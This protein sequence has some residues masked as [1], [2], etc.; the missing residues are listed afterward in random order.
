L[1]LNIDMTK[2]SSYTL[3]SANDGFSLKS[4]IYRRNTN[5][6]FVLMGDGTVKFIGEIPS[7]RSSFPHPPPLPDGL[8][9]VSIEEDANGNA[10]IAEISNGDAIICDVAEPNLSMKIIH[11]GRT[12]VTSGAWMASRGML[13][14]SRMSIVSGDGGYWKMSNDPRNCPNWVWCSTK[15]PVIEIAS[16]KSKNTYGFPVVLLE[17]GSICPQAS[18]TADFVP[19]CIKFS[20]LM[21]TSSRHSIDNA[22]VIGVM[23]CGM[24]L[25]LS[26]SDNHP[27]V[28]T[29]REK[30]RPILLPTPRHKVLKVDLCSEHGSEVL[31]QTLEATDGSRVCTYHY[32]PGVKKHASRCPGLP[33]DGRWN[34]KKF[35]SR[36]ATERWHNLM[37]E[38]VANYDEIRP[39]IPSSAMRHSSMRGLVGMLKI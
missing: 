25:Q 34:Y 31:I 15:S 6:V 8:R 3:F 21:T 11:R 30:H 24:A 1:D 33:E 13:Y 4:V 20:S 22:Y 37:R 39:W 18:V 38:I 7:Y 14:D 23:E 19:E 32:G 28:K 9:Y 16:S 2:E 27:M 29:C 5:S 26:P 35:C 12:A 36:H 10:I 17:D